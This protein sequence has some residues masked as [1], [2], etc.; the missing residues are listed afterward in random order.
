M[1]VAIA[2]A[3][4]GGLTLALACRLAGIE[5]VVHERVAEP[6]E[7]GAGL[8]ISPNG[9]RVLHALGLAPAIERVAFKPEAVHLRLAES[10]ALVLALPLGAAAERR[11]GAPYYQIHRGDLHALL[12]A[13]VR[14]QCGEAAV[15]LGHELASFEYDE[16][17]VTARFVNGDT[18]RADV[19]IGADGIH[20]RTR[21]CLLGED[22]ADY[23]GQVA[24]RGVVAADKL[25][26]LD[27]APVVTSWMAPHSHAITYFLRRGELVNFVGIREQSAALAE[28]WTG[29]GDT[30]EL[31]AD[32]KD[33]HPTVRRIAEHIERPLRWGL[34][35]RPPLP[36]WTSGRAALLGDACHPMLPYMAQGAVMA[37]EDA[38]M[39]AACLQAATDIPTALNGYQA[40]RI[41][42]TTR[43]QEI[44]RANGRLFHLSGPL[45]RVVFGG[46]AVGA[47]LLPGL[48]RRRHDWIMRYDVT[49][50]QQI[51]AKEG[52]YSN[53]MD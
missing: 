41:S 11:Y 18:D 8:Q 29:E 10:G 53:G 16:A 21:E 37:I 4:I 35:V 49:R 38:W 20:S 3:G 1:K 52:T 44:A 28:S 2:G 31:L 15:C 43:V 36:S 27:L 47:R 39:L 24:W 25:K 17:G 46:M 42:R 48:V 33:W 5:V 23:T 9:A 40:R 12:L 13:A 45:R 26:K 7:V 32:L 22:A 51:V 14:Q 6:G 19:L 50:D 34:Y 30:A